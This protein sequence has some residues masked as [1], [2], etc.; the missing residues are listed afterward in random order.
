MNGPDDLEAAISAFCRKPRFKDIVNAAVHGDFH[1]EL[2]RKR[3]DGVDHDEPK[4]DRKSI[5]EL[6][7]IKDK[8][9]RALYEQQFER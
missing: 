3:K 1:G 9:V 5:S 8:E 2:K 6:K 7:E 4:N